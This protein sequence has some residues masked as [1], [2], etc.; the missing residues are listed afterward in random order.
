MSND[1]TTIKNQALASTNLTDPFLAFADAVHPQH[2][3]GKLLKHSKGD[4][5]AGEA[6]ESLPLNTK[7]IVAMDLLTAGYVEWSGGKPVSHH[8]V[9][10]AD[11]VKPPQRAELGN[12]D[13]V[14]WEN[15]PDGKPRDPFQFTQYLPMIDEAGE[16]FTFSTSARGGVGALAA[17]ARQYARGRAAHRDAFPVIELRS[18]SYP[19]AVY[20]R[21]KFPVFKIIGW[22]SKSTFWKAAGMEA[23]IAEQSDFGHSE[24]ANEMDDSIPF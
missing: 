13:P 12:S 11:G 16:V 10:V 24:P 3:L 1:L 7:M 21:V 2:I 23:P 9:M 18:D 5:L 15:G 4:Y 22:E 17:L 19:H 20:G 8:M 14:N 6:E